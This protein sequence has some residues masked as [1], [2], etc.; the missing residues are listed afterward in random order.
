MKPDCIIMDE[1]SNHL[2]LDIIGSLEKGL[3][4]YEGTVIVASHDEY[5]IKAVGF[6]SV[7]DMEKT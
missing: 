1:P 2:D 3:K 6:E 7:L 5:F 4:E